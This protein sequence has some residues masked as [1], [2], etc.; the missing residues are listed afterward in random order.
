MPA[1]LQLQLH[2]QI[3]VLQHSA[4]LGRICAAGP[5]K[6]AALEVVLLPY[7]QC[8]LEH[9]VHDDEPHLHKMPSQQ[10]AVQSPMTS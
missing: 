3:E 1:L 6:R 8:A 2:V 10:P 4:C 9:I 7:G 5:P